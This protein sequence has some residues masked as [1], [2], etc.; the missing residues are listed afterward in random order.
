MNDDN[1]AFE[2]VIA[3]ADNEWWWQGALFF[4]QHF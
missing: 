1:S 2:H 3:K 4:S